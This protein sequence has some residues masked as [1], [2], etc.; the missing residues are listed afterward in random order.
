MT[1]A[2]P[3]MRRWL[4]SLRTWSWYP[5]LL[6]GSS[7]LALFAD[8]PL[9]P[10]AG[11]RPFLV[12]LAIGAIA[13]GVWVK[14]LG[15]DR[16]GLAAVIM[17][18]ALVGATDLLKALACVAA[19]A[20]LLLEAAWVRCGTMVL[21]IPWLRI[22]AGLNAF[23]IVLVALQVGR[24][25]LLRQDFQ[26]LAQPASWWVAA[27]ATG[28]DVILI[29][30]DGHGREDVLASGYGY[31]MSPFREA[32]EGLGFKESSDSHANHT[33]TKF[34][35]SVLL[36]GRPLTEMGQDLAAPAD[37]SI[38]FRAL[39]PS[40]AVRLFDQAGYETVVIS[41]GYD[42]LPL[43]DVDHYIDVGPRTE[44]EQSL[45]ESAFAGRVFD[46]ISDG[47]AGAARDRMLAEV[48]ALRAL[49]LTP[50][51]R[52]Q[53]VLAHLPAPHLP[54][55]MQADCSLRP[56]DSYTTGEVGRGG[57][58][59]DATAIQVTADQHR[60]VDSLLGNVMTDLVA[61]RPGAVV[62]L[63]SD[64]GPEER[65]DWW[66]PEEPGIS[67]RLAVLFLAR[68]PG[69]DGLF[70]ADVSLVNVIPL[71]ANR[72]LGTSIA[73]HADDLFLGPTKVD[74]HLVLYPRPGS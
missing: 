54:F 69:V 57:R 27:R 7:V 20:L 34:S 43:R 13:T 38:P 14:P 65:L 26:P 15:R 8:F 4:R 3:T 41:S 63:F 42:H 45:L 53:F 59:G 37:A 17:L 72:Y 66:A 39:A 32:L 71:I 46:A 56:A 1:A 21:R 58:A 23:V 68:T 19:L 31:D 73:P 74:P 29:L 62:I 28:P 40:S 52:P 61:A 25:V 49:A 2:T 51:D 16:A 60:C 30:A 44:I 48:D 67:D 5:M 22:T 12:A 47:Y 24:A 18:A 11:V 9:Q 35:L 55:A 36:N 10:A 50:S 70:P 64:H 6:A 33:V